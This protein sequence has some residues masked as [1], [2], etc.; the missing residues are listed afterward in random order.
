MSKLTKPSP[1]EHIV[2]VDTNI[3]WYKDK[4]EVVSP[5]FDQFWDQE[6]GSFPMKLMIP[7]VV[8]GELLFQQTSSA[9][10]ALG[11]ANEEIKRVSSVTGKTYS[12]Q[13]TEERVRNE[14]KKRM[15][16]WIDGKGAEVRTTPV[17]DMNWSELITN[18]TWR[19]PPFTSDQNNP[20]NEKGFRDA[21]ILET[22]LGFL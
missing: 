4:S 15:D 5:E 13:I 2:I 20:K 12:H 19:R 7:E 8:V 1:L 22:V 10:K 3:L 9:L 6:S 14:V 18:A 16:A 17:D 21:L 11:K